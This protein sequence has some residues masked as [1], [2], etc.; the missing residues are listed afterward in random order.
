VPGDDLRPLAHYR[1]D[2]LAEALLGVLDLP[3]IGA[4]DVMSTFLI[5]LALSRQITPN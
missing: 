3:V 4:G 2:H 1:T 5:Y